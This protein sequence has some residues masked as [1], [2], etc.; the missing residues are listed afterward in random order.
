MLSVLYSAYAAES[1]AE[2]EEE[3]ERAAPRKGD[4]PMSLSTLSMGG[5]TTSDSGR[6]MCGRFHPHCVMSDTCLSSGTEPRM[7]V[8]P[9]S[10]VITSMWSAPLWRSNHGYSV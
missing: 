6:W 4:S 7:K 1:A 3:D 9:L 5:T 10:L 2:E 8:A